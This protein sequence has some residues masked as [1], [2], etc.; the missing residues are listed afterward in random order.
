VDQAATLSLG[1]L[2]LII[3]FKGMAYGLSLGAARGGP[4][5]PAMFLGIIAG[6]LAAHL[7]GF[8][9]TPA[10]AALMAAATVSILRLPLTSVVL[11]LVITQAG[12]ATAPLIIVA[13]AVAFITVELLDARR[14][15][16]PEEAA[17]A[18][19]VDAATVGGDAS[20]SGSE[21]T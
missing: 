20:P 14:A 16:A 5:F 3:V 11:A 6:L 2:A 10:V 17:P 8:S 1:T 21:L 13:V 7:P 15:S 4:T 12:A 9:E 18:P 19:S